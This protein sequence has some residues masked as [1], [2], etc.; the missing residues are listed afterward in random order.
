VNRS[1][2]APGTPDVGIADLDGR[3]RIA[4]FTNAFL[5]DWK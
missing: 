4:L 5:P 2:D 1:N 3:N